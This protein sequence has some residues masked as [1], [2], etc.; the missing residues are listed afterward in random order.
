SESVIMT[1]AQPW[2]NHNGGMMAFG[3]DGML[4]ISLGDGGSA[5]DPRGHG[6]NLQTLLGSI[7][8]IDI[9]RQDA[10]KAY[11]VPPDNPFVGRSDAQGEIWA[12]G[13]RNVWRFSFDRETG[14][15]WGGDVGQGK[16]EE[17]DL[18]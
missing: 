1:V 4:Y 3:P 12:Y 11:A 9:D 8:R 17:I 16:W 18:I 15:L 14:D 6:Q 13:L 7:L 5:N 2:G 10:G